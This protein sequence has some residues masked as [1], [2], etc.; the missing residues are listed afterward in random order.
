M[1]KVVSINFILPPRG[2]LLDATVFIAS[3]SSVNHCCVLYLFNLQLSSSLL[4]L[5]IRNAVC[6]LPV[7]TSSPFSCFHFSAESRAFACRQRPLSLSLG[8]FRLVWFSSYLSAVIYTQATL[9]IQPLSPF[10]D[11]DCAPFRRF[12]S[13]S[14]RAFLSVGRFF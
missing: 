5:C 14:R 6:G 3:C 1:T 10:A 9:F 2:N 12:L 11:G 4:S 8:A 13:L 7:F